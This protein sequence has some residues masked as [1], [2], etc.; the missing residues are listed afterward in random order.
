ETLERTGDILRK[1]RI[2]NVL[3]DLAM[4]VQDL[5]TMEEVHVQFFVSIEMT[6]QNNNRLGQSVERTLALG[7]N[8]VMVGLA[9]QVALVRERDV[10]RAT[11]R[12]REF[13]GD[14]ILANAAAIKRHTEEIG[15]VYNSPVIALEKIT[16]AH[17]DLIEAMDL[18]DRLKQDGIDAAREN[19]AKLS[20]LSAELTQRSQGLR[21][22]AMEAPSIEA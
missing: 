8:V 10:M 12:T 19:I 16:Q 14:L 13:L 9:L 6:R 5:R 7:T 22:G 2:R 18:A 3:H 4:R 1:E 15:D 20:Q 21:E 17:N 11:Q